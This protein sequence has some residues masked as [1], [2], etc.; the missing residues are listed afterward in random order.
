MCTNCTYFRWAQGYLSFCLDTINFLIW[1]SWAKCPSLVMRWWW[2]IFDL[3]FVLVYMCLYLLVLFLFAERVVA[4]Y[5]Y[6]AQNEDELSFEKGDVVTV[7][8]KDEP[9]WWKGELNGAVGLFPSNYVAPQCKSD[10][11][12]F[13]GWMWY[14]LLL[15]LP[16]PSPNYCFFI[17]NGWNRNLLLLHRFPRKYLNRFEGI[18]NQASKEFLIFV[19]FSLNVNTNQRGTLIDYYK[20]ARKHSISFEFVACSELFLVKCSISCIFYFYFYR[21]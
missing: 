13:T 1:S 8:A 18:L 17:F 5:Q 4:L 3:S 20:S 6:T 21:T 16:S 19:R 14:F 2:K 15:P 12:L 9:S 11:Q 7:L 10:F